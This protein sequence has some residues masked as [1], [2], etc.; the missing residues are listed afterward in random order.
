LNVNPAR[1]SNVFLLAVVKLSSP[2]F[3]NGLAGICAV[4]NEP[5]TQT[6]FQKQLRKAI[7][8]TMGNINQIVNNFF[9]TNYSMNASKRESK[10]GGRGASY[11]LDMNY[12][13]QIQQNLDKVNAY[14]EALEREL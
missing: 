11:S 9:P 14:I 10:K 7:A 13:A 4:P 5:I 12:F 2:I 6:V 8:N 3:I 1:L